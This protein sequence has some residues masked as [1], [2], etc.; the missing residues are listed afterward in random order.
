MDFSLNRSFSRAFIL[1]N[2]IES[3]LLSPSD[4]GETEGGEEESEDGE[5]RDEV[6]K[7]EVEDI[8]EVGTVDGRDVNKLE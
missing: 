1:S 4:G 6:K 2:A 8:S 7:G 3:I 5:R